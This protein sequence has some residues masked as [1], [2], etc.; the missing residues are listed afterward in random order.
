VGDVNGSVELELQG[1]STDT[2]NSRALNFNIEEVE[3]GQGVTELIF[4]SSNFDQIAGFQFTLDGSFEDITE[5]TSGQLTVADQHVATRNGSLVMSWNNDKLL[6]LGEAVL[7]TVKVQKGSSSSSLD[8]INVVLEASGEFV[9]ALGQNEPNPWRSATTIAF[10]LADDSD[11]TI[12]V[13][14]VTGKILFTQTDTYTAGNQQVV[15]KGSDL[16]S[17]AG[18]LYYTL[19]SGEFV[20]TK[21]MLL[22][23]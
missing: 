20:S 11:A 10:T 5:V 3:L 16:G 15:I 6:S 21:K 12:S 19:E 8:A 23:D 14:D 9:N 18:V 1:Q 22:I 7:F 17:A 13:Y 2:R 4:T